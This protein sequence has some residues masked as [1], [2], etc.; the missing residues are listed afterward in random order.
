MSVAQSGYAFDRTLN[1]NP[2]EF[3]E[4]ALQRA[5]ARLLLNVIP[6]SALTEAVHLLVQVA[7]DSGSLSR[8]EVPLRAERRGSGDWGRAT[9][10]RGIYRFPASSPQ[11]ESEQD[12][13]EL[14]EFGAP[15]VPA[16]THSE[17]AEAFHR[18]FRVVEGLDSELDLPADF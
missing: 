7:C 5:Q 9:L 14:P 15:L 6:D 10:G 2:T 3:L 13:A 4:G 16:M 17:R 8:S 1:P 12:F 18:Q 11:T